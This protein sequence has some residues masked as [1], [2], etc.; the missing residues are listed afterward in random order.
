ML[1][2]DQGSAWIDEGSPVDHYPTA[3][4]NHA[5]EAS[6]RR[7]T[8]AGRVGVV[9]RFGLFYGP[10]ARHSEQFLALARR[11]V[12]PLIGHPDGYL[13][14]IHVEDGGRAVAAALDAPA[15]ST[16]SSTTSP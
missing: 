12:T 4:G 15:G 7:F 14:S 5:A 16:T 3:V 13:S 2:R 10:G 1:Y 8:A 9:L 6:A 11:G